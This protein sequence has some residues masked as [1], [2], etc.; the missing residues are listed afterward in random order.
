MP[1]FANIDLRRSFVSKPAFP[2]LGDAM[3]NKRKRRELFLAETDAVV[4]CIWLT[5]LIA[6]H[7]PTTGPIVPQSWKLGSLYGWPASE[8]SLAIGKANGRCD[9]LEAKAA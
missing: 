9:G 5:R 2:S 4:F 1:V 3:K 7:H 6:A 8:I